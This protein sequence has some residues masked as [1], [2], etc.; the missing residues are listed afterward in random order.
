M[1]AV[2]RG[3]VCSICSDRR[4][5]LR[6]QFKSSR[7]L[8]AG[9]AV[10]GANVSEGKVVVNCRQVARC[11]QYACKACVSAVARASGLNSSG[12]SGN[13]TPS[14]SVSAA[15]FA[16]PDAAREWAEQALYRSLGDAVGLNVLLQP[17]GALAVP[18]AGFNDTYVQPADTW[19][20]IVGTILRYGDVVVSVHQSAVH[21]D[22]PDSVW[23]GVVA[24]VHQIA[25][26]QAA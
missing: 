17:D 6:N 7:L 20:L 1:G 4:R 23:L 19:P 18:I 12:T 10:A 11:G 2:R 8:C 16:S 13:T 26:D 9:I 15:R 21:P 14:R 22:G 24:A 5:K 3:G 25:T